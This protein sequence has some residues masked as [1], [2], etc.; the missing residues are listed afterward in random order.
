M[1][2]GGGLSVEFYVRAPHGA[3]GANILTDGT[4][5]TC[6]AS[7]WHCRARDQSTRGRPARAG[8]GAATISRWPR[9]SLERAARRRRGRF[10]PRRHGAVDGRYVQCAHKRQRK[11]KRKRQRKR[12]NK[13]ETATG[14]RTDTT[15]RGGHR[16]AQRDTERDTQVQRGTQRSAEQHSAVHKGHTAGARRWRSSR[17]G[18][19]GDAVITTAATDERR[20]SRTARGPGTYTQGA[21]RRYTRAAEG[22]GGS[23]GWPPR[24]W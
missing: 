18:D 15:H 7:F 19:E 17:R 2:R 1:L 10:S 20:Q 22:G 11:R 13:Q 4:R 23:G 5:H 6:R 12:Q 24:R 14:S 21:A 9:S 3:R 16:G 8:S